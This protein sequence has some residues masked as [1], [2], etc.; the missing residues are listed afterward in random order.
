MVRDNIT[1]VIS[2]LEEIGEKLLIWFSDNQMKLITDKYYLLLNTQEQNFLKIG[3]FYIKNTL[4][5]K[6]LGITF[7]CKEDKIR[8]DKIR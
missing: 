7:D 4:S 3:N 5:E 2:A 8:Y 1:N 6:L